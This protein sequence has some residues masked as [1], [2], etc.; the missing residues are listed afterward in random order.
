MARITRQPT[1]K[2]LRPNDNVTKWINELLSTETNTNVDNIINYEAF[3]IKLGELLQ[4]WPIV[5]EKTDL[6][7]WSELLNRFDLQLEEILNRCI[8]EGKLQSA[9]LRGEE[10][11]LILLILEFSRILLETCSS[12]NIYHSYDVKLL[13]LF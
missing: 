13:F 2:T 10:K 12:R 1:R 5:E 3:T 11:D 7:H 4:A 6:F 9:P 8:P